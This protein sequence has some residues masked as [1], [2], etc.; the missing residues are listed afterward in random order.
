M[1]VDLEHLLDHSANRRRAAL[2]AVPGLTMRDGHRGVYKT[3][4]VEALVTT[5]SDPWLRVSAPAPAPETLAQAAEIN[6]CLPGNVHF[7][8]ERGKLTLAADTQFD[9]EAHLPQTFLEIGAGMVKAHGLSAKEQSAVETE[10]VE[11]KLVQQALDALGW[12]ESQIVKHESESTWELRPRLR[13]KP[14]PVRAELDG[15]A[16]RLSR[17]VAPRVPD[18]A[19]ESVALEAL[20]LNAQVRFARYCL[21]GGG[22]VVEARLH[23]GLLGPEWLTTAALA[24][25]V[26]ANHAAALKLLIEDDTTR[27]WHG[28][29]FALSAE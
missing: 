25:A 7:C 19:R 22:L 28:R 21:T 8:R 6:A 24:V 17:T 3:Q 20:R 15:A 4:G 13:G 12:D 16:L 5:E 14:R 18:E 23:A 10:A 9:G 26:A 11:A 27:R 2:A 29:V 1:T